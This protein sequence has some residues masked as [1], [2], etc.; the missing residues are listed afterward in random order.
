MIADFVIERSL[1]GHFSTALQW[2]F[3]SNAHGNRGWDLIRVRSQSMLLAKQRFSKTKMDHTVFKGIMMTLA[4]MIENG[5]QG[6]N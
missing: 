4:Q 5:N 2:H 3:R 6:L 1:V